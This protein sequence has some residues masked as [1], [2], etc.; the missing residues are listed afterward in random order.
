M[1]LVS[2]RDP[3][4]PL[5]EQDSQRIDFLANAFAEYQKRTWKDPAFV[6]SLERRR[7]SRTTKG[8]S[9]HNLH[10]GDCSMR[11]RRSP[12]STIRMRPGPLRRIT[13]A[14]SLSIRRFGALL[15]RSW[16]QNMRSGAL[17]VFRF[18][19]STINALLLSLIF[20][21]VVRGVPPLASS[22][23]DRV[24]LLSFG[25]INMAFL[26]FLKAVTIFAEERVRW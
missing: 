6:K 3:R 11:D 20:P 7:S 14:L 16:R 17:H 1:D 21:T 25:A 10:D 4:D 2:L 13:T 22:V 9:N 18:C 24:A 15:R 12:K 23:A 26:A 5:Y 19:A 8:K